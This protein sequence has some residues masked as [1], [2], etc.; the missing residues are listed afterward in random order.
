MGR[1][2]NEGHSASR[3]YAVDHRHLRNEMTD[4]FVSQTLRKA[5]VAPMLIEVPDEHMESFGRE[6]VRS[7]NATL[8]VADRDSQFRKR[9]ADAVS[10]GQRV[11]AN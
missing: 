7:W 9:L 4:P 11:I 1:R 2:S 5:E 3:I 6:L 8:I 10:E